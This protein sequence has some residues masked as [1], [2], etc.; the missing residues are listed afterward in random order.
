MN[1]EHILRSGGLALLALIVFAESGMLVG[2]FF[3]GDS[4][5]FIAGFLASNA[6]GH[7]LPALPW[8]A[9]TAAVAAIVGDQ[10]GYLIGREL[11][12][13]LFNRR[14]SKL[15]SPAHIDKAQEFFDHHGPKAIVLARFVPV[16]RAF[17]AVVAGAGRMRYRTYVIYNVVGGILWGVG[18]STLGYYL[19]QHAWVKNHIEIVLVAV[20]IISLVPVV[21]E[22]A[23]QRRRA[24]KAA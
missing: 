17:V 23:R 4:L 16:V 21:F 10:V 12:P 5:L 7:H 14:D 9:L 2:F 1:V 24:T 8:V 6:G 20:V 22:F 15:L 13:R 3:P 18:V 11:G 19:G